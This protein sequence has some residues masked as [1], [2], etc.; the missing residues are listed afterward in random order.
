MKRLLPLLLALTLLFASACADPLP[1]LEDYADSVEV[2]YDESDP[3]RGRF[4][5]S[6]RYPHADESAEGGEAVNSYYGYKVKDTQDFDIPIT[7]DAYLGEGITA[8]LTITY[9]VTCNNDDYFSVLLHRVTESGSEPSSDVWEGNV[10]SRRGGST[11]LTCT[12]PQ[13]LG[14]LATDE[15]DT[16]LQDRQTEKAEKL[17]RDII[18]ER[19]EDNPDGIDYYPDFVREDLDHYFFPEQDFYLDENGDP[20][21]FLQVGIAAPESAGIIAFP[22]PLEEITDEL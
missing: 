12:L 11:G 16:W 9:S 22:I 21:F 10:F 7:A 14:I 18:W 1:L 20:V 8:S 4:V 5:Y 3:A 13:L 17:V 6:Y 2:L 19:I 15:N